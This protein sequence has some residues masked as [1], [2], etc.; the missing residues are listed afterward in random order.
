LIEDRDL[1][2]DPTL[3]L[4]RDPTLG[5]TRDLI[6]GLIQDLIRDPVEGNGNLAQ[7]IGPRDR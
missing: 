4:I 2:R 3:G 1:I 6:R 7:L 5:R